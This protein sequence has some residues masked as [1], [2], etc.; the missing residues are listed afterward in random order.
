MT[1][2]GVFKNAQE[3]EL[4]H[5]GQTVFKEGDPGE[6]MYGIQEGEVEIRIGSEPVV[7]LGPGAILGEMALVSNEPRSAT[8]IA[9]TDCRL[10]PISKKR[11]EF[12]VQQ[13]PFFATEVM[14]VMAEN[15]RR[16]NIARANLNDIGRKRRG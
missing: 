14:R 15:L 2:F 7:T 13:T 11:F 12:M 9:K 4:F 6:V 3:H 5:A 10:V 16:S 8:A 1:T